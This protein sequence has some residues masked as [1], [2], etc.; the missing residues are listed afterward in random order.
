[1]IEQAGKKQLSGPM[2]N[3]IRKLKEQLNSM[4]E[5]YEKENSSRKRSSIKRAKPSFFVVRNLFDELINQVGSRL[6]SKKINF[7]VSVTN[8]TPKEVHGDSACLS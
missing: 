3:S 5:V 7:K 6:P 4:K 1:M 8:N 2:L